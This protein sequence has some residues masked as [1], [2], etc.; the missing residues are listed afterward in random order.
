MRL[1]PTAPDSTPCVPEDDIGILVSKK[2]V[3]IWIVQAL[4]FL[5]FGFGDGPP[6][7]ESGKVRFGVWLGQVRG[8]QSSLSS[9]SFSSDSSLSFDS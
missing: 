9:S 2:A 1:L 4:R 6:P 7:I 3:G 8:D 5:I